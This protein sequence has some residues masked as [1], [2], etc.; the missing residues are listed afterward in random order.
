M[1]LL[2]TRGAA[3][4]R[5]RQVVGCVVHLKQVERVQGIERSATA[6]AP[7]LD[8]RAEPAVLPAEIGRTL[9]LLVSP[10][11]RRSQRLPSGLRRT[12]EAGGIAA[13]MSPPAAAYGDRMKQG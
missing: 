7:A 10:S 4:R 13:R 9:H 1:E 11:P 8:H 5:V 2:A 6:S 12:R 3:R